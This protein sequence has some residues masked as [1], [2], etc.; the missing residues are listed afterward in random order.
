MR[1]GSAV[2]V[3]RGGRLGSYLSVLD[4]LY[5][6]SS[7]ALRQFMRCGSSLSLVEKVRLGSAVSVVDFAHFG[8]SL[9]VRSFVRIGASLSVQASPSLGGNKLTFTGNSGGAIYAADGGGGYSRRV[10]FPA[11]T[12]GGVLHGTWVA[13]AVVSVSDRRLK[14]KIAPLHR[15][16]LAQMLRRYGG[17]KEDV[18]PYIPNG[19]Q[20]RAL[21]ELRAPLNVGKVPDLEPNK[22][23]AVPPMYVGS[24]EREIGHEHGRAPDA[25]SHENF[26]GSRPRGARSVVTSWVLRELRPVSFSFKHINAKGTES[27]G[28][29]DEIRFGFVAQEVERAIPGI[30]KTN[31]KTDQRHLIYQDFIALLTMAAQE[32]QDSI[33]NR[34]DEVAGLRAAVEA[35]A[36]RVKVMSTEMH[37]FLEE[38]RKMVDVLDGEK[39]F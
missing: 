33:E 6:G 34:K 14:K 8:S 26:K 21:F 32:H 5:L 15:E 30:V 20:R 36:V 39:T 17:L 10:S 19:I 2:A 24:D 23:A 7:L 18:T 25:I 9:S 3:L 37:D 11:D 31:P 27:K 4:F 12:D 13:D 35:L 16:L 29:A 1:L 22:Q 28:L 38:E